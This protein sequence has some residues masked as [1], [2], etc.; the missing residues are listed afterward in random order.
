MPTEIDSFV[1]PID[2]SDQHTAYHMYMGGWQPKEI[3]IEL[4]IKEPTLRSWIDRGKW[5]KE[6]EAIKKHARKLKPPE[7][8]GIAKVISVDKREE[9]IAKFRE[10]SGEMAVEDMEHW[11]KQTPAKRLKSA[12]KIKSLNSVHRANL[13]LDREGEGGRTLISLNFLNNPDAVKIIE[14][15][16]KPE[17]Q[18]DTSD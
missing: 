2:N 15:V 14:D 18:N 9:N 13:E 12:E 6:R 17:L 7:K 4:K 3:A 10:K 11:A 5:N 8:S 1:P 16:K